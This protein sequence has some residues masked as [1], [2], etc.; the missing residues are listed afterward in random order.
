MEKC[1][2]EYLASK[3]YLY[4]AKKKVSAFITL[5]G[6][7]KDNPYRQ[8]QKQL[9]D[10]IELR[11]KKLANS[12]KKRADYDG[13]YRKIEG[14][15]FKLGN[16]AYFDYW[17]RMEKPVKEL[18]ATKN[19]DNMNRELSFLFITWLELQ[20]DI[21]SVELPDINDINSEY[22]SDTVESFNDEPDKGILNV[23][24]VD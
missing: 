18:L 12:K 9:E 14:Y 2:E 8:H 16:K 15:K 11:Y 20:T 22:Y 21:T 5:N 19:L 23:E 4:Q 17:I 7:D 1:K 10:E 24:E 13:Q 6:K 3:R